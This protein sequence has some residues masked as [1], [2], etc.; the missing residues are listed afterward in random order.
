MTVRL[1]FWI[2]HKPSGSHFPQARISGVMKG[3]E[4]VHEN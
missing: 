4:C 2:D 1:S 3:W